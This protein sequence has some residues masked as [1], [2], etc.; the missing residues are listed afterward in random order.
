MITGVLLAAGAGSRFGGAKLLAE[1]EDGRCL[2]QAAAQPLVAAV[3]E[4]VA[5]VRPEDARLE[6]ILLASGCR[7]VRCQH[8]ADGMGASL[9]CG[10]GAAADAE[11]WVV[12]LADMPGIGT[13]TIARVVTALRRGADIA[14]PACRGR[15]G[16]PV[17]FARRFGAEL[18]ALE[19]DTGAR[20]ILRRYAARVELL[21]TDD[22]GVLLDV[23][24]PGDLDALASGVSGE[25]RG[26]N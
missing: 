15:R 12:G 17:G 4:V 13:A 18:T 14:A 8:A 16:H 19:G 1:L 20:G 5:V 2:A 10:V 6:E 11:G 23:D 24:T 9:A 22:P 21:E 26:E 3:D 7:T 25:D